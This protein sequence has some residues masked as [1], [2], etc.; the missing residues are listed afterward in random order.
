MLTRKLA[1]PAA[2]LAVV[3]LVAGAAPLLSATSAAAAATRGDTS[4][5]AYSFS[6]NAFGSQVTASGAGLALSSGRSAYVTISCTRNS[7]SL[8]GTAAALSLPA[9]T[10]SVGAVSTA[11]SSTHTSGSSTYS[12]SS[13]ATIGGVSLLNGAITAG[14]ISTTAAAS[15]GGTGGPTGS[16]TASLADLKIAGNSVSANPAPNTK[17]TVA[18]VGTVTL[19]AQ[20][21]Q[22]TSGR[23]LVNIDAIDVTIGSGNTLGLPAGVQ[24]AIGHVLATVGG[25]VV[26]LLSGR[27]FGTSL[28]GSSTA[29]SEPSFV[30]YVSCTGGGTTTTNQGAGATAGPLTT[31]TITDTA[32][33]TDT[34]SELAA[35]TESKVAG[36]TVSGVLTVG[37]VDAR[38]HASISGGKLTASGSATVSVLKVLGR[39]IRLPSTIPANYSVPLLRGTLTLNRQVTGKSGLEVDALYLTLPSVGTL[40]V[41]AAT[42]YATS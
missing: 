9:L 8:T 26:G 21:V 30:V 29:S 17:L 19:N 28:T 37:A 1:G 2:A 22:K 5:P 23:A 4:A 36:I 13:S 38:A 40:I 16:G 34:S 24:I 42:A 10:S 39:T 33:G 18:G 15:L 25:P 20:K 14:A 27:A 32:T 3:G 41:G 7:Q 12:D 31:G 11:A 6:A 35:S